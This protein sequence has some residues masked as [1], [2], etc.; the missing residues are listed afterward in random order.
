MAP[1]KKECSNDLHTLVIRHYQN[2][3]SLSEVT[4]KT[5]LSRP[6][7]QYAVDKYKSTKGIGHLFGRGRKRKSRATKDRLI[8]R[9]Q[10]LVRRK[11]ASMVK[12]HVAFFLTAASQLRAV[13]ILWHN[14]A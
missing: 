5:L 2:R 6:T 4:A 8:Q 12:T 1:K 9:K 11:S 14:Y 13:T 7:V 3:D 10:K